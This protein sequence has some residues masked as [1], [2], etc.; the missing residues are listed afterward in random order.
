M[1]FLLVIAIHI[2]QEY[3]Y[4]LWVIMIILVIRLNT[5]D[6]TPMTVGDLKACEASFVRVV[7]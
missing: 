2:L 1:F 7:T 6:F 3:F 4:S 5:F